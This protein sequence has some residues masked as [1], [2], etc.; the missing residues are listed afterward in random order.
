[1]NRA[2]RHATVAGAL[3]R[4]DDTELAALL[5]TATPAGAGIGGQIAR[6]VVSGVPVVVKRVPLTALEVARGRSTANLFALPPCAHYG[7]S[8]PGLGAWREL[9]A[10][11]LT[12]AWVR[13]GECA[14]FPLL[15]HARVVPHRRAAEL[16]ADEARDV[17]RQDAAWGRSPAMR[18]R[19]VARYLA[20]AQLVLVLE[21]IPH[22]LRDWLLAELRGGGAG[23]ALAMVEREL[24][25]LTTFMA[26][27]GFVHFDAHFQNILTDGEHLYLADF[28]QALSATFALSPEEQ[29]FLARHVDFD[30]AYTAMV[31]V[32][33]IRGALGAEAAAAHRFA[34]I[35]RIMEPFFAA[36]RADKTTSY[37][38]ADVATACAAAGIVI[39]RSA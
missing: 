22:V 6:L 4:L 10:H 24:S 30:A 5:A 12:T 37:P 13:D 39:G 35:N 17:E 23:A 38:A 29:A 8:S 16:S 7:V 34:G 1:V 33:A 32:R 11:E 19:F 36:L 25:T 28:G 21:S 3:E 14:G 2:E 31:L 27:R 9:V 18:E 26:A 20:P 15:H